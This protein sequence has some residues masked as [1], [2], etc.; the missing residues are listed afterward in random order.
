MQKLFISLVL[1][2]SV[3]K[4]MGQDFSSY[5]KKELIS[6]G[7]TLRYRIQYPLSYDPAKKYPLILLLHGSGERGSDNEAQLKW[8]GS[9]FADSAK[10]AAFPAIVVFPQ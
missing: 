10:R 4:S 8:G 9:L 6:G 2:I 3:F 5:Q 7:D 1:I